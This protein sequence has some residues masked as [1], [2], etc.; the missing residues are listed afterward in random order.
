MRVNA[1]P[2]A[3]D[4]YKTAIVIDSL[5]GPFVD[6]ESSHGPE[7]I[8]AIRQSGITA[9][10]YTISDRRFEIT[11]KNLSLIQALPEKYPDIV[12]IVRNHSDTLRVKRGNLYVIIPGLRYS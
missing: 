4:L 8:A 3:T 11:I 7:V 5:A 6:L 10:N 9:V 12:T 2:D 1:P